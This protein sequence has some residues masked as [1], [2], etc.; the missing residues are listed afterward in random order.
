MDNQYY[1]SS[2]TTSS[3]PSEILPR[4]VSVEEMTGYS[5]LTRNLDRFPYKLYDM[6]TYAAD[7]EHSSAVSWI[8]EGRAFAIHCEQTFM[9][10]IVPMF[11]KQTKFRS[12]TRQLNIWGFKRMPSSCAWDNKNFIRGRGDLLQDIERVEIKGVK[13]SKKKTA[14]TTAMGTKKRSSNKVSSSH[15]NSK[16]ARA[17]SP[18]ETASADDILSI[19]KID[20]ALYSPHTQEDKNMSRKNNTIQSRTTFQQTQQPTQ[21]LPQVI[22]QPPQE[23]NYPV[24]PAS[25]QSSECFVPDSSSTPVCQIDHAQQQPPNVGSGS[26]EEFLSL[27]SGLFEGEENFTSLSDV[28]SVNGLSDDLLDPI[29]FDSGMCESSA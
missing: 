26:D 15:T 6:L 23:Y 21:F 13:D 20:E 10:H 11:F 5:P 1:T 19:S 12:F 22:H 27:L 7:C 18:S 2:P 8:N 14:A 24:S 3:S 17:V 29:A 9:L 16:M 25:H 28:L 4:R